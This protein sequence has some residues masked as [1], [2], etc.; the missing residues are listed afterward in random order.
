MIQAG[1]IIFAAYR[2]VKKSAF[3]VKYY[4]ASEHV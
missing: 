1:A 3:L 4:A 2:R